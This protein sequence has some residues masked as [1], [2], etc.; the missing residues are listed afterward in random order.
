MITTREH[1]GWYRPRG[2]PHFDTP[3][4]PQFVTFRLHDSLPEAVLVARSGE[5]R[6]C[7]RRRLESAL[8]A[9][10]GACWL[11]RPDLAEIVE[12]ALVHGCGQTH[13]MHA[14]TI[15]P[16]HVHVLTTF[17]QGFRMCDI[18]RGWKS[19]SARRINERL[20]RTGAFWQRDYFD[21]FIRHEKHFELVRAYIET[22]PVRAGLVGRAD[23]WPFSSANTRSVGLQADVDFRDNVGLE[24]DAPQG[25]GAR[26]RGPTSPSPSAESTATPSQP[27]PSP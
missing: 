5:T 1:K 21:R 24:A 10:F 2:L 8:D 17:R 23:E 12:D 15:M 14:F 6:R 27:A 16:N 7:Y 19:Y 20:A 4:L 11:A 3:E 25:H 9:G 18:L 22:N 26:P 13:D